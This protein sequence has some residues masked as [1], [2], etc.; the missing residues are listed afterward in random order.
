MEYHSEKYIDFSLMFYDNDKLIAL[1]P[2][3]MVDDV[4][5]SHGGLTFGG[6]ISD[7]KMRVG[8]MLNNFECLNKYLK[9][10]GIAKLI[11]K[12]IPYIYASLPSEEDLFALK[13]FNAT[14]FRRDVSSAIDLKNMIAFSKGKKWG[15]NIAKKCKLRVEQNTDFN[16]FM[17]ILENNLS[18][19]YGV[20]PT[21][22]AEE[23][24]LLAQR[25]PENIKLFASYCNNTMQAGT[26]IYESSRVAH[27]QYIAST[28]EGKEIG[29]SEIL[30][31]FLINSYYLHKT[32]FD[33]GISTEN[34]GHYLNEGLIE[35]KENYGARAVV[36]DFYELVLL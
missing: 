36:H 6:I 27:T 3:N 24:S 21:H 13:Y 15:T 22:T 4:I 12:A 25:F 8:K 30:F 14:L 29:A 16:K 31:D 33:F 1:M 17:E 32:Y 7:S 26:I 28:D 5:C 9:E 18:K 11:Y 2:A 35:S 20:K 10:H 23:I 34:D 19:R